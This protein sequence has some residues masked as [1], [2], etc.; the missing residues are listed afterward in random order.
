MPGP[1]P[2]P[3]NPRILLPAANPPGLTPS[4]H[5]RAPVIGG[6]EPKADTGVT[7]VEIE[8]WIDP[9]R[10]A[11]F[12]NALLA[13]VRSRRRDGA[14]FWR[15]F[16]DVADPRRNVEMFMTENWLQHL[17]QH[18]RVTIADEAVETRVRSFHTGDTPVR[19]VHLVSALAVQGLTS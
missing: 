13:T 4:R 5:W 17:R 6:E 19:V 1:A 2:P 18:E 9:S 10:Q 11:E 12:A 14:I 7:L 3:R 16:V 15:H 8:Y